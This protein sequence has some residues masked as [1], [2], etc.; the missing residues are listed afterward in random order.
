VNSSQI[1]RSGNFQI[2][3]EY[4][5]VA[6]KKD[7]G[8]GHFF[9]SQRVELV[10]LETTGVQVNICDVD[11]RFKEQFLHSFVSICLHA[12][13]VQH[14]FYE[15][16]IKCFLLFSAMLETFFLSTFQFLNLILEPSVIISQCIF[17]LSLFGN[18]W[19]LSWSCFYVGRVV[20]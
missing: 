1:W 8:I 13:D 6:K 14:R 9:E 3:G 7:D 19:G 2:F 18:L 20:T 16:G 17:G 12:S 15:N 10:K 5:Q 11:F 4:F